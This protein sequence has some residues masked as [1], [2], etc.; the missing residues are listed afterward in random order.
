MSTDY[1]TAS[2]LFFEPLTHEDVLHVVSAVEPEGVL[3]QLGGQ[4]PL[5]L[6]RGLEAAG[7]PVRGTAPSAIHAAEDREEFNRLCDEIGIRQPPGGTAVTA[8]EAI[9]VADE[10]GFPVLVRPSYVLG[11]RSMEIIY[12]TEDLA[13]AVAAMQSDGAFGAGRPLLIDRFLEDAVEVDVDC[14]FDGETFMLGGILEHIEEAGVH[15]GDSACV[16]P[17]PTLSTEVQEQ[18][19]HATEQLA[20]RLEVCGLLNVQYAVRGEQVYVIEANPRASRTVP[21]V[22][23]AIN[24]PLAKIAAR[25]AMGEKI[26]DL[27]ADGYFRRPDGRPGAWK[28]ISVKEAVLPFTRFPGSDALIGP[29]MRSTG[30]VMGIDADFGTAYSKAQLSAGSALPLKGRVF[31]S[32]ADRDKKEPIADAVR[33]L[34]ESGFEIVATAGTAS[35]LSATGVAVAEE[36]AKLTSDGSDTEGVPSAVD[37]IADGRIDVVFNTPRGRGPR[38]DGAY[39]RTAAVEADIPV[40]TTIAG[41]KAAVAAI[42]AGSDDLRVRSLQDWHGLMSEREPG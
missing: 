12:G 42:A 26:A 6:A 14:C 40:V 10:I 31:I 32:I 22:S 29:E 21:F 41:A 8:D 17:P 16:I 28:H 18:I 24:V 37:L 9:D 30:E 27:E 34:S 5:G 35:W 2:Q 33:A 23:K 25:V 13:S 11:G 19:L 20:R 38:A 36:V 15:S 3:L 1:D 4:T 7:V 39:I